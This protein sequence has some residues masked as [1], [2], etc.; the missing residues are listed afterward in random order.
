MGIGFR[1]NNDNFPKSLF[2]LKVGFLMMMMIFL[3]LLGWRFSA[4]LS[5]FLSHDHFPYPRA[6]EVRDHH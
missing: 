2:S 4:A 6:R 5:E 1:N 3:L